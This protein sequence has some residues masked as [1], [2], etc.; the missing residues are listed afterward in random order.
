MDLDAKTGLLGGLSPARFMR[1]HWQAEPLL[2]RNAWPGVT[3]PLARTGLFALAARDDVEARLV[4][5]AGRTWSL[6][7]GPFARRSLPPLTQRCWT[8][9]VQGVDLH[10]EAAHR[11]LQRFRFVPDARLDDLMVSFAT[12]GGGV[13]PHVD[14]YDVFLLQ[15]KGRRRWRIGPVTDTTL[16]QGAPLKL[17]KRFHPTLDWL[18]NPG[19]MLYLPPFWGHDGVAVGECMTG[20]IGFR[21]PGSTTLLRDLLQ[22]VADDL[23]DAAEG[24]SIYRDPRQRGAASPARIPQALQVFAGEAWRRLL[25]SRGMLERALGETLTEPKAQVWFEPPPA[26][27]V[28]AGPVRVDRRTRM[29]YDAHHVFVNGES[30]ALGGRDAELLRRLADER[31]LQVADLRQLSRPVRECL[32]RW[33]NAG[34]LH[35]F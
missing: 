20:S 5:R 3:P 14:A 30:L 24:E 16:V 1:R 19:D 33:T 2:V 6:R 22:R 25:K 34:W 10:D 15:L 13:G 29:L 28:V 27:R 8:L 21:A 23:P 7:H 12:D 18:L 4:T 35:E 17:L 32:V 26:R 31:S 9:L 11:L